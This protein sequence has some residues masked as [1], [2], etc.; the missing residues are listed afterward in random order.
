VRILIQGVDQANVRQDSIE[1]DNELGDS[2]PTGKCTIEDFGAQISL[3]CLQELVMLNEPF[4]YDQTRNFLTNPNF[5]SS[6][7]WTTTNGI[8]ATVS[9]TGNTCSISITNRPVGSVTVTQTTTRYTPVVAG[10]TYT[11]SA[12]L[13][14]STPFS[15][16]STYLKIDFLDRTGA[17]ISSFTSTL[18][19]NVSSSIIWVDGLAP[20]GSA[21]AKGSMGVTT[22]NTTNSGVAVY[23]TIQFE[24][25]MFPDVQSYPTDRC[26]TGQASCVVLANGTC[27]RED[28]LFGGLITD[29]KRVYEDP[30]SNR[31]HE[32]E[33]SGWAILLSKILATAN[34]VSQTD[35]FIVTDMISTYASTLLT[36]NHVKTNSGVTY[37]QISWQDVPLKDVFNSLVKSATGFD[38]WVDE[39]AD[40]HYQLE[41]T[42]VS[43]SN[44]S[45]SPDDSTTFSFYDFQIERAASEMSNRIKV[46]GGGT[47]HAIQPALEEDFNGD[48]STKVFTLSNIPRAINEVSVGSTKKKVGVSNKNTFAQG[49]DVLANKPS[50]TITFNVAPASGTGNVHVIYTAN[51]P[52]NIRMSDGQSIGTYGYTF[53]SKLEDSTLVTQTDTY[54]RGLIA[55]SDYSTPRQT[56]TLKTNT[57]FVVGDTVA[58]TSGPEMWVSRVFTIQKVTTTVLGTNESGTMVHEYAIQVGA[59]EPTFVHH[60][61]HVHKK[62][63]RQSSHVSVAAV[64]YAIAL[65]PFGYSE[66]VSGTSAASGG[67]GGGGSPI[68]LT[69]GGLYT[70]TS[71]LSTAAKMT[72]NVSSNGSVSGFTTHVGTGTGWGE[73]RCSNGTGSWQSLGSAGSP[74][75]NGFLWDVTTL[76][77][78]TLQTGNWTISLRFGGISKAIT[79]SLLFRAYKRSSS[80]TYTAIGTASL[81]SQ[82]FTSTYTTYSFT[83]QSMSSMAFVAGDKLYCDI[84]LNILTNPN[85]STAS[86]S[87]GA[88]ATAAPADSKLSWITPGYI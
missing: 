34:Y 26:Y 65:E 74:S 64:E 62:V 85:S 29:I 71:T 49:Y 73:M 53:D 47:S 12:S 55:L 21:Y 22:T 39:Y 56:I 10:Q 1:I 68:A 2:I 13:N 48:A 45:S 83:P 46:F 25:Q 38:L 59:Y 40:I 61:L 35:Y 51:S 30:S 81:A 4:A 57:R 52:V 8:G 75:G 28:R 87:I 31:L 80:G 42:T 60:L 9:F 3:D 50:M 24:P 11:L 37:D 84:W 77:G 27:V 19:T 6:S 18:Y 16:A 17:T 58:I 14:T 41:G 5:A 32:I 20:T 54:Q 86:L 66:A 44:L 43:S 70:K 36:T 72:N 82:T 79:G 69:L 23:S 33:A 76:E 88:V 63:K 7:N 67:G 78:T 15:N